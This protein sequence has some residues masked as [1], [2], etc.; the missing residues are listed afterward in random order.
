[1]GLGI[2]GLF[3]YLHVHIKRTAFR[4]LS[5]TLILLVLFIPLVFAF[6]IPQPLIPRNEEN[7]YIVDYRSVNTVYQ[8][9]MIEFVEKHHINGSK[10]A[11]DSVT[12][13]QIFGLTSTSFYLDYIWDNPLYEN[14]TE[15]DII[16]L[17][18]SGI[19]GPLNEELD[20]R[21][22]TKIDEI[23][24]K[25]GNHIIYDNGESFTIVKNK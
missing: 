6:F 3:K 18:Y 17:H 7:E 19:S 20:Y 15:G 4:N 23:K 14:E 5:L 13:W 10:I 21:T 25:S 8:I 9:S 24:F 12:S 16:L 1:M 2:F 22:R 11:A